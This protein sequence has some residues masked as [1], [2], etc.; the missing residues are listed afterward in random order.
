MFLDLNAIMSIICD[1]IF[2]FICVKFI[3]F[4]FVYIYWKTGGGGGGLHYSTDIALLVVLLYWLKSLFLVILKM[5]H[6]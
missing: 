3:F 5:R 1:F 6:V 2:V 4:V